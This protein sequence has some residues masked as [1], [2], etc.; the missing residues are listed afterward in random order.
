MIASWCGT[1]LLIVPCFTFIFFLIWD[2]DPDYRKQYNF[3]THAC[4]CACLPNVSLE[5]F[6]V[7]NFLLFQHW[8]FHS[9]KSLLCVLHMSC[10][11]IFLTCQIA[12]HSSKLTIHIFIGNFFTLTWTLVIKLHLT[13]SSNLI[14][15]CRSESLFYLLD[16]HWEQ[17]LFW[18]CELKDRF[19]RKCLTRNVC[20]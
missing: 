1:D 11:I 7:R 15:L 20:H 4:S 9:Y 16:F 12:I 5:N 19:Y 10:L 8:Y 17:W 18:L 13:F 14:R 2:I 3:G 6:Q